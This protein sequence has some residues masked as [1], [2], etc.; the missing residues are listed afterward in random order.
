MGVVSDNIPHLCYG[1]IFYLRPL[2]KFR[3][4]GE[5][6]LSEEG[7][8]WF[9]IHIHFCFCQEVLLEHS[10]NSTCVH[11]YYSIEEAR[12]AAGGMALQCK[13]QYLL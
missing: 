6:H 1:L 8:S 9:I 5:Y 7:I 2:F 3:A 11:Y 4:G 10:G 13:H 12:D